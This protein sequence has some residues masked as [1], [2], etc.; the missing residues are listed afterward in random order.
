MIWDYT[1][2]TKCT[3]ICDWLEV[4]G[5]CDSFYVYHDIEKEFEDKKVF[6]QDINEEISITYMGKGISRYARTFEVTVGNLSFGMLYSTPRNVDFLEKNRVSFKVN[7]EWLYTADWHENYKKVIE[8]LQITVTNISRLDVAVD[9]ANDMLHFLTEHM[10]Q[11][12]HEKSVIRVGQAK[13]YP[14]DLNEKT[15]TFTTVYIGSNKSDKHLICYNKSRELDR[16]SGKRYIR[17]FWAKNGIGNTY[18][19]Y[20]GIEKF[21]GQENVNRVEVSYTNKYMEHFPE[22]HKDISIVQNPKKI[23][24]LFYKS[25]ERY[26]DFRLNTDINIT[27]CKKLELIPKGILVSDALDKVE[28]PIRDQLF[29]TKMALKSAVM[30]VLKGH[31]EA[32]TED[33]NGFIQKTVELYSL[34]E[35]YEKRLPLWKRMCK[36][37]ANTGHVYDL[38]TI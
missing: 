20:K 16:Q 27:R 22:F 9:G 10:K 30:Q 25:I 11:R 26:F 15:M 23:A 1:P 19:D 38:V 29:A 14:Y 3:I 8:S 18:L 6:T 28:I 21:E 33:Y 2:P 31:A 37:T 36:T 24:G 5:T 32:R 17:K 34:E 13:L 35:W 4:S 12:E 7:N